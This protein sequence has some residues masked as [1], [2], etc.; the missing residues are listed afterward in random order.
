MTITVA[1]LGSSLPILILLYVDDRRIV[2]DTIREGTERGQLRSDLDIERVLDLLASG[3]GVAHA[4]LNEPAAPV[5]LT[6]AER[7]TRLTGCAQEPFKS[8]SASA[9]RE[10]GLIS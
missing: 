7:Q 6:R 9:P 1:S 5:P 8:T 3:S 4:R 2:A 10:R